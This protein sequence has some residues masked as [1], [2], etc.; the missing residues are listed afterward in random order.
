M[1]Y[2]ASHLDAIL[3]FKKSN[4]ILAIHSNASYLTESKARIMAGGHFYLADES[5]EEEPSNG[6]VHSIAQVIRNMMTLAANS[7]IGALFINSK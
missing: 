1:D 3:T 6:P 2:V 7:K 4:M 5:K